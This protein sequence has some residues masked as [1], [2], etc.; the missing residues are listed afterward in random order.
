MKCLSNYLKM[1]C[2]VCVVFKAILKRMEIGH[3]NAYIPNANSA[4]H[5]SGVG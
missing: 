3:P 4:C 1:G 5:L 2:T